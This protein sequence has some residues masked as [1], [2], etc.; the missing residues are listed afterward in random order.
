[1]FLRVLPARGA[2]KARYSPSYFGLA[3][4]LAAALIAGVSSSVVAVGQS[5]LVRCPSEAFRSPCE[6]VL[7]FANGSRYIRGIQ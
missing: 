2:L 7:T 5:R 1:M 3:L 4:S 6:G